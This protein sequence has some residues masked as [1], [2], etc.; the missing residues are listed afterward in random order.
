MSPL[1]TSSDSVMHCCPVC[2]KNRGRRSFAIFSY[3]RPSQ[4]VL[5][6]CLLRYKIIGMRRATSV[7]VV[8][9]NTKQH[10][11][12]IC[13]DHFIQTAFFLGLEIEQLLGHFPFNGISGVP[14][15]VIE[16]FLTHIRMFSSLIDDTVSI[17]EKDVVTLF[18]D[19]LVAYFKDVVKELFYAEKREAQEYTDASSPSTS[20]GRPVTPIPKDKRRSVCGGLL[21]QPPDAATCSSSPTLDFD[22]SIEQ[23]CFDRIK[24]ENGKSPSRDVDVADEILFNLS[25][26]S[27]SFLKQ[28]SSE[29]ECGPTS[30]MLQCSLCGRVR[31]RKRLKAAPTDPLQNK[32]LFS[33]LVRDKMPSNVALR[34]YEENCSGRAI[35]CKFHYAQA[36]YCIGDQVRR[37]PEEKYPVTG[38]GNVPDDILR[39]IVDLIRSYGIVIEKE[40]SVDS[41]INF[42][43]LCRSKFCP[44]AESDDEIQFQNGCSSGPVAPTS[45]TK[46]E[47]KDVPGGS[48][49]P[50][51]EVKE[52]VDDRPPDPDACSSLTEERDEQDAEWMSVNKKLNKSKEGA[53]D[54][55]RKAMLKSDPNKS[56]RDLAKEVFSSPPTK[57]KRG[58]GSSLKVEDTLDES[59]RQ[60]QEACSRLEICSSLYLR[61]KLKGFLDRIV[62]YE[63]EWII[64]DHKNPFARKPSKNPVSATA[65]I[66]QEDTKPKESILSKRKALLTVWWSSS[67]VILHKTLR[68]LGTMANDSNGVTEHNAL[69][70]VVVGINTI[71]ESKK[72]FKFL[73][74]NGFK[75]VLIY[76][77]FPEIRGTELPVNM[78]E[79]KTETHPYS[80]VLG[81][82]SPLGKAAYQN[83][84]DELLADQESSSRAAEESKGTGFCC[85][86]CGKIRPLLDARNS[87][88]K[89]EQNI[90][91]LSCLLMENT[92]DM[93][94]A[95][96]LYKETF[97]SLRRLCQKHFIRAA[98][99]IGREIKEMTGRFPVYGLHNVPKDILEVF[100]G[101]IQVFGDCLDEK[102]VLE[103]YD[104]IRF[105]NDCLARYPNAEEWG[106]VEMIYKPPIP[107]KRKELSPSLDV[108]EKIKPYQ[109]EAGENVISET[110]EEHQQPS[111][112]G[113]SCQGSSKSGAF[114]MKIPSRTSENRSRS[115]D[116]ETD[117]R[118]RFRMS[119][120]TFKKLCDALEPYLLN[121]LQH[122][123]KSSTAIRVGT[124]LEILAG[125]SSLEEAADLA[126]VTVPDI[127]SD[128]L[129]ALLDWSGKM[130][131]WP[132][133][134]ELKRISKRFLEMTD[135]DGI[136]G[137][138]DGTIVELL[139]T[140]DA[141]DSNSCHALNVSVVTDDQNRI[142]WVFAKY[143]ADVDDN[144]VFKRSLLCEQLKEGIKK[145]IL[146]GD[147][148]YVEEPFLLTPSGQSDPVRADKLRK[149]QRRVQETIQ[150]WKRQFPILSSNMKTSKVARIIVGTAALYNLTRMEG[151]PIFTKEEGAELE[152]A[153]PLADSQKED[154]G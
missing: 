27:L 113:T 16:E 45:V 51:A 12:R 52:E 56:F 81:L 19:C 85:V 26:H 69:S 84:S 127:F 97:Q 138:L 135:I 62:V 30:E 143:R 65:G 132:G 68:E 14:T 98:A 136:V 32:M 125:K 124:A 79:P 90:I 71:E 151:E 115:P 126:D 92:I 131:Q 41:V 152:M 105:F 21:P 40:F 7:C 63:E 123:T 9:R 67:G 49:N 148:E 70:Y 6:S 39:N 87:L 59:H 108:P 61:N 11:S 142:R 150:N 118:Q 55:I 75:D 154:S 111:T 95:T 121:R 78:Q 89:A 101:H 116:V 77:H 99:F 144:S 50:W 47:E 114:A 23:S 35:V 31:P 102:V 54:G 8:M 109:S 140:T 25:S 13:K 2:G 10:R 80:R 86:L 44:N 93:E 146:I 145:G 110:G 4:I 76:S 72:I 120:N 119:R 3:G 91:F 96:K 106:V 17:E 137:C 57:K 133:E 83:S 33:C 117:F 24:V 20:T 42:Y 122:G 112:A 38:L 88:K 141:S 66:A 29:H 149:T 73:R 134:V 153:T 18:N 60:E 34:F 58:E 53:A 104:V 46:H 1:P 28:D 5:L 15:N 36:A 43:N 103:I 94:T 48:E 64:Y 128:V 37:R 129:E 130:I 100:L 139:S 22:S 74:L 82:P 147:D 107:R